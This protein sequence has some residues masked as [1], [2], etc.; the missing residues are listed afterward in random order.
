[1]SQRILAESLLKPI[2]SDEHAHLCGKDGD[3]SDAVQVAVYIRP[4]ASETA[5]H[6][7]GYVRG[8]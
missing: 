4:E 3:A 1:M 6:G 2:Y 8:L 7:V 5:G